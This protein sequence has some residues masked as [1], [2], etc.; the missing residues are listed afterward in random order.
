MSKP[1]VHEFSKIHKPPQNYRRHMGDMKQGP[2]WGS[3]NIWHYRKNL[4]A[5]ADLAPRIFA[6]L[7]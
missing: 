7:N 4:V 1:G 3:A 6:P 2:N 5:T